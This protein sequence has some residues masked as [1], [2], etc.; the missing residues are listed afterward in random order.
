MR[1]FVL[2]LTVFLAAC[3]NKPPVEPAINTQRTLTADVTGDGRPEQITLF[4]KAANAH[5]PVQWLLTIESNGVTI[6]DRDGD[7]TEIDAVFNDRE[8][9]P[10]CAD[11]SACKNQYY[12]N[13][14]LGNLIDHNW[15]PEDFLDVRRGG[16]LPPKVLQFLLP[17]TGAKSEGIVTELE[18]RIRTRKAIVISPPISP[19]ES[20]PRMV[21]SADAAQFV[22][23]DA[24]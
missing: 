4:I 13:D 5:A 19:T 3:D 16:K 9:L 11:Y 22:D 8:A 6:F 21:Y 14:M 15:D 2:I 12:L 17:I 18:N 7:D 20:G 10:G 23:I 24:E 1:V